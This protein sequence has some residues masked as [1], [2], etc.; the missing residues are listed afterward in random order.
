MSG[1]ILQP[2]LDTPANILLLAPIAYYIYSIAFPS[3]F[4]KPGIT[5]WREG[6]SWRP[7]Q[8]PP[9]ILYKRYSPKTLAPFDGKDGGRILLAIKG[10]V[11]D[12]SAG[13][14]FYGPGAIALL[15]FHMSNAEFLPY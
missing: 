1:P 5:E 9:T 8:H 4:S 12:V 3:T 6:Y 13:R 10:T 2:F 11:F 15:F 7:A 14:G